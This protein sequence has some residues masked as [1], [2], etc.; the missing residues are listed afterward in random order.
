MAAQAPPGAGEVRLTVQYTDIVR[1]A[2]GP[3]GKATQVT[4]RLVW[5]IGGQVSDVIELTQA[6]GPSITRPSAAQRI[7]ICNAQIARLAAEFISR[8]QQR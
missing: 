7:N 8:E 4:A 1:G 5:S 2:R 3:I 6:S